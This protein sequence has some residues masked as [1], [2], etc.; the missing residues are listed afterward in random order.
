MQPGEDQGFS[1]VRLKSDWYFTDQSRKN[2]DEEGKKNYC[3]TEHQRTGKIFSW[4][5][6]R[7]RTHNSQM[8]NLTDSLLLKQSPGTKYMDLHLKQYLGLLS[9]I[10]KNRFTLQ[11]YC[12]KMHNHLPNSTKLSKIPR[13]PCCTVLW[14]LAAACYFQC[15]LYQLLKVK[16]GCI[17]YKW[18][19]TEGIPHAD[20]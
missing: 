9:P 19:K 14:W 18:F 15:N 17:L 13:K 7:N 4:C 11:E 20:F 2:R 8:H 5:Y 10:N 12:K 6:F 16:N 1:I 3:K